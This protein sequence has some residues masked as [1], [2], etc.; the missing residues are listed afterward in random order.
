MGRRQFLTVRKRRCKER[1]A[2]QERKEEKKARFAEA[3]AIKHVYGGPTH[4]E[5]GEVIMDSSTSSDHQQTEGRVDGQR[6]H[7][8]GAQ[9]D[10]GKGV[11]TNSF[12]TRG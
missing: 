11:Q 12:A 2:L 3:R 4:T 9:I 8:I 6:V 5:N 7:V 1:D 10:N